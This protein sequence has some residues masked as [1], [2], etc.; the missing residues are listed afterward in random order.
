MAYSMETDK[1]T[2]DFCGFE[3]DWDSTDEEHG[4]LWGCEVCGDVVCSKC[5]KKILGASK[6]NRMMLCSDLI[7][8][9]NCYKED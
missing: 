8:C 6:Y 1:Y 3:N 4:E 5:L 9:P 2:C 7:C